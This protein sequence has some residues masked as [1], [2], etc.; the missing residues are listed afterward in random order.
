[1]TDK[2]VDGY[3]SAAQTALLIAGQLADKRTGRTISRI[4]RDIAELRDKLNPKEAG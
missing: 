1:M 4:D 2:R 3:L